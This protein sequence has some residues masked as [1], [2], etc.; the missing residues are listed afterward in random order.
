[1]NKEVNRLPLPQPAQLLREAEGKAKALL[2]NLQRDQA[3]LD[4][5]SAGR[6]VF[7]AAVDATRGTVDNLNRSLKDAAS[8]SG[9]D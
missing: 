9:S 6:R 7:Q 5:Q 4:K 1:M 3:S 8:S 2:Q